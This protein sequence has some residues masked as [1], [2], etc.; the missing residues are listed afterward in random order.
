M[1]HEHSHEHGHHHD[2][3]AK[4]PELPLNEF[5]PGS[6]SLAEALRISFIL[7][8]GI[9]ILL[10]VAFAC[11]GFFTVDRD[12][13][14]V[15]LRLG[16]I[17]G[18]GEQAILGPGARWSI[19]YPV[20][21]VIKIPVKRV[22]SLA[23]DDFWYFETEQEKLANK[24]ILVNPGQPLMPQRDGYV[25]TRNDKIEALEGND[26]NIVHCKWVLTYKISDPL[27]F[28]RN[29]YIDKAKPGEDFYD[30]ATKTVN[31]MLRNVAG[32]AIVAT[33]VN[34]SIDE[35][36][37]RAE[38]IAVKVKD[39]MS[40]ELAAM[41]TG[42]V[43]DTMQMVR[44]TWP[45]QVDAEFQ[46]LI[47]ARQ[48][49]EKGMSE[50][51]GY[52]EQTLNE[53]GGPVTSVLLAKLK[54]GDEQGIEE[55]WGQLAG[56]SQKVISEARAYRTKVVEDARSNAEYMQ[57]LLP[58]YRKRP[59]LVIQKIYQDAIEEVMANADEKIF[60]QRDAD[61]KSDEVRFMINSNPVKAAKKA[62][63]KQ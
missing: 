49:S 28:F 5:D 6:K 11:S 7:L 61:G 18:V 12:E 31:P 56:Q 1:A 15:I 59:Q 30:V 33:M 16:K 40:R 41:N 60:A 53:A 48:E 46:N 58:E 54:S 37:V 62:E 45:R 13:V 9:M 43:V 14:A 34:Y 20:D 4:L 25:I 35:A 42:I 22:Q 10:V 27:E 23:I 55:L 44:V 47:G 8:K 57:S 52:T 51:K 2:G 29:V 50:A 17:K 32:K 63:K 3:E 36:L 26:Y 19:P 38:G 39:R 21:E 24:P